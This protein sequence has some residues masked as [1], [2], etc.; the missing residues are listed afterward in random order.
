MLR[1]Y[2]KADDC[3]LKRAFYLKTTF[4]SFFLLHMLRKFNKFEITNDIFMIK[5]IFPSVLVMF[6]TLSIGNSQTTQ[7]LT[8]ANSSPWTVLT[9]VT[10][11]RAIFTLYAPILLRISSLAFK[12]VTRGVTY[13]K[14]LTVRSIKF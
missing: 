12:K 3:R 1:F 11:V 9:R 2:D 8:K 5:G 13:Y 14:S 6:L 7:T 10:S 4:L